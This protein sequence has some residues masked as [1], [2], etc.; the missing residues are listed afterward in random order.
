YNQIGLLTGIADYRGRSTDSTLVGAAH[1]SSIG[2]SAVG[3]HYASFPSDFDPSLTAPATFNGN[4]YNG[5]TT[6][7]WP[8]AAAPSDAQF[9]Y[10]GRYQLVGEDRDYITASGD[11]FMDATDPNSKRAR[12]IHWSFD[13]R[14]SMTSW[15]E[16]GEG[17]DDVAVKNLGRALG[18]TI[19]NGWQLNQ[20]NGNADCMHALETSTAVPG[21]CFIP[22][23]VYFAANVGDPDLPADRGTC[24]WA[25]Y[26]AMGR[27]TSQTV[28]TACSSCTY[29]GG[30]NSASCADRD[31]SGDLPAMLT[32]RIDYTY[33]WDA[34]SQLIGA[35]KVSS[36]NP[37]E[38]IVMSYQYD[39]GGGRVIREKSNILNGSI[40]DV[41]QDLYLGGTERRQVQL[42]NTAQEAISIHSTEQNI[43]FQNV[44]DTRELHYAGGVRLQ[45]N[46]DST[47]AVAPAPQIFLSFNNHL[48]STSA[49]IDFETGDLVEWNTNYAYGADESRWKNSDAKYEDSEDPYGFTGKEE[50]K[51]VGLHYFGAR[52]YSSYLGRWLSPDPPVIHGGGLSNH[53]NY[54]GNSPYIYVDP[55]GNF[56]HAIIAAIVGGV[57]GAIS[58][59]IQ[60]VRQGKGIGGVLLGALYG[61]W[62]GST[63]AF[64][65]AVGGPW[66]GAG[67][68]AC[69][70]SAET[71]A[72]GGSVKDAFIQGNIAFGVSMVSW[73][74]G[75]M[76]GGA[77]QGITNSITSETGKA[78]AAHAIGYTAS[79]GMAYGTAALMGGVN[80][81]NWDDILLDSTIG[82]VA[83]AIGGSIEAKKMQAGMGGS[84]DDSMEEFAQPKGTKGGNSKGRSGAPIYNKNQRV[85]KRY[86]KTGITVD[87]GQAGSLFL[88]SF[89][90]NDNSA[91]A[92]KDAG[93]GKLTVY[94]DKTHKSDDFRW[95]RFL[96]VA[97]SGH[98]V[99]IHNPSPMYTRKDLG[100]PWPSR[101]YRMDAN[102]YTLAPQSMSSATD[103]KFSHN[104]TINIYLGRAASTQTVAH[105]LYGHAYIAIANY[106]AGNLI[107]APGTQNG[108]GHSSPVFRA[109]NADGSW[110]EGGTLRGWMEKNGIW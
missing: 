78:V 103:T 92:F 21:N 97:N 81:E 55:D 17:D 80:G 1:P 43:G 24:I 71:L 63:I 9:A 108:Y 60:A 61:S 68:A 12:S 30:P 85:P 31:P 56:I 29:A 69:F 53:Y 48:G 42:Q 7:G 98:K 35:E 73:G 95:S 13:T 104:E 52:Y 62:K 3:Y 76:V 49:V 10:D 45:W 40:A 25:A 32:E 109:P 46:F 26:D 57:V 77:T 2:H 74:I 50:D 100:K 11:D 23:A 54:G 75:K 34:H 79:L 39:A 18:G 99:A 22:D 51:A 66:A 96:D 27:M 59:A 8:I 33:T 36:L 6:T 58:G 41:Y 93:H 47:G 87:N 102:G 4:S 44:A 83:G 15:T 72:R 110:Y 101:D 94:Y 82:Y 88:G 16:E 38:N 64:A 91:I 20:E 14:G 107:G 67:A 28:R 70:A 84:D 90:G 86:I 19:K 89:N 65:G 106:E 37:N 5:V 105:E